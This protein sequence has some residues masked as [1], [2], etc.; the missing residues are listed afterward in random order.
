VQSTIIEPHGLVRHAGDEGAFLEAL[1]PVASRIQFPGV[2]EGGAH[3]LDHE[4]S[5][6][7]IPGFG[8]FVGGVVFV[9]QVSAVE[10]DEHH[11]HAAEL[12]RAEEWIVRPAPVIL[13]V[14]EISQLWSEARFAFARG[15]AV[16]RGLP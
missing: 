11:E 12:T 8:Q 15:L 13:D 1:K 2:A 4:P 5:V 7:A 6:G 9:F 14:L 16:I 3:V 10:H